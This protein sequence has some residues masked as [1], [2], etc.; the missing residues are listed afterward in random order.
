[1]RHP[2]FMKI[3]AIFSFL[4]ATAPFVSAGEVTIVSANLRNT[5]AT[6]WSINVTLKHADTGWEHFANSW[7]I[8]DDNGSVL[9]E[10]VLHHP[11]VDEQPFTRSLGVSIPRS[12]T[13]FFVEARDKKHGWSP[14]R[15]K[16]DLK[17]AKDGSLTVKP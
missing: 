10:R 14:A 5:G 12:T 2:N 1:M 13:V 8:V 15:L 11:H 7:R 16:I 9:G 3:V 6:Q 4:A 17:T